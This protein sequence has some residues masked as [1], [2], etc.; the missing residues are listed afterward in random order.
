MNT[1]WV[2]R[3]EYLNVRDRRQQADGE[4]CIMRSFI[5]WTLLQMLL[6]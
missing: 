1:L 5:T 6:G 3:A 2:S 4:N